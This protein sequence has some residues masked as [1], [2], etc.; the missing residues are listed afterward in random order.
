ME[1]NELAKLISEVINVPA[2]KIRREQSLNKDLGADSLDVFQIVI[3]L[4]EETGSI[5]SPSDAEKL[6]TVGDL[7][8]MAEKISR[9]H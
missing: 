5:I 7:A 1:F 6:R 9:K 8:D 4:E 2:D 3:R